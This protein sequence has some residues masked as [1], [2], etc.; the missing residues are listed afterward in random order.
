MLIFDTDINMINKTKK[1]LPSKFEMK[2][3]FEGDL[4]LRTKIIYKTND[5]VELSQ[6][7]Y[8]EKILSK[9]SQ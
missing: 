2:D 6:P 3:L 9:L 7:H 1:F 4:I 5:N 8:I